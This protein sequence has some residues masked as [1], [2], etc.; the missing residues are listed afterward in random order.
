MTRAPEAAESSGARVIRMGSNTGFARAVNRGI[1]ECRTTWVAIVN[2]DIEAAPD[3]LACLAAALAD[4]T[5]W[6]ATGKILQMADRTRLDGAWDA[7]ARS[8]CAWRIGNGR[9]DAPEYS[10]PRQTFFAPGTAALFRRELFHRLG[11]LDERF[12]SYLEDIDF[13]LRC[14][15]A[16]FGGRYIPEAVVW[17]HG[18]ATFGRWNP[19][20]VRLISRNQV[21]LVARHYPPRLILCYAWPILVGQGLWGLLALRHGAGW[22]WLR[23]KLAGLRMFS[24]MRDHGA[25]AC[26]QVFEQGEL[27]IYRMQA[28]TG[29]DSYWRHYFRLVRFRPSR[30]GE[31]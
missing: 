25:G 28:K 14:A 9:A 26:T 21:L 16:G 13:G 20:T 4:E 11:P 15:L 30:S 7:I 23:G 8:A 1:A 31:S 29:F 12:E 6:F 22:A 10:R 17:H 5:A 2:N 18:S 3:W 24:A 19:R 27:E